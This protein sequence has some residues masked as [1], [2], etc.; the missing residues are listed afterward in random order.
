MITDLLPLLAKGAF[1][2]TTATLVLCWIS[3]LCSPLREA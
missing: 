2:G 3:H 1:I